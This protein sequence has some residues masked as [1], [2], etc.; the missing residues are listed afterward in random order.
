MGHVKKYPGDKQGALREKQGSQHIGHASAHKDDELSFF[1]KVKAK[2][3]KAF[4]VGGKNHQHQECPKYQHRRK[5]VGKIIADYNKGE[6]RD[7]S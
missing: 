6:D 7:V 5:A 3:F 2:T 1:G 4:M